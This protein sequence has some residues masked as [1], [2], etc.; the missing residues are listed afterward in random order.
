MSLIFALVLL[1][2]GALLG[3]YALVRYPAVY[4]R[5]AQRYGPA[6]PDTPTP[7]PTVSKYRIRGRVTL[8]TGA[9]LAGVTIQTV[10][11]TIDLAITKPDGSYET[12]PL[13][14]GLWAITAVLPGFTFAPTRRDV[15]LAGGDVVGQDFSAT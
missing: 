1:V 9:P 12:P 13:S 4:Y 14:D 11:P 15:G 2:I 10:A 5:L 3:A 8:A 6:T 7:P